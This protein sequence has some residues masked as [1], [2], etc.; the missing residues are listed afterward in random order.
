MHS[1]GTQVCT[2]GGSDEAMP[3]SYSSCPSSPHRTLKPRWL[4]FIPAAPSRWFSAQ[5]TVTVSPYSS[6]S[7][8]VPA[9]IPC[10]LLF[11]DAM[12]LAGTV[13]LPQVMRWH[14]TRVMLQS[15]PQTALAKRGEDACA[16]LVAWT[17][18]P[19]GH[20]TLMVSPSVSC[21][22]MDVLIRAPCLSNESGNRSSDV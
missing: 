17:R 6:E 7:T 13:K 12:L 9:E 1:I 2:A 14:S 11:L 10:T 18:Y 5:L 21:P 16:G 4:Q 19:T 15:D 8:S 20:V 3:S 22:S